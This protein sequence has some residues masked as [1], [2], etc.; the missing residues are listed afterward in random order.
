MTCPLPT[1]RRIIPRG[2]R[3]AYN[4]IKDTLEKYGFERVQGSVY[5]ARTEDLASLFNA[6]DALRALEWFGQGVRNIRA[7]RME[8]GSD[9]TAIARHRR[10]E[11][12]GRDIAGLSADAPTRST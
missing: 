9:F 4:D 12:K 6:V 7:F 10:D 1:S 8:Q 11:T 3:Q 2:S 5:A